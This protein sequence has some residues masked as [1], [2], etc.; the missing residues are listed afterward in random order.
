MLHGQRQTCHACEGAKIIDRYSV[1][2]PTACPN[3][4]RN[5]AKY[6]CREGRLWVFFRP[7]VTENVRFPVHRTVISEKIREAVAL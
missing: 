7:L 5:E 3:S 2:K 4:R 1:N 6:G